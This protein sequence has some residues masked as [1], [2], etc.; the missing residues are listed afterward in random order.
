M[1]QQAAENS[2]SSPADVFFFK[3]IERIR[4][5]IEG[6]SNKDKQDNT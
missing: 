6:H 3:F 4:L 1:G 5:F 2:I